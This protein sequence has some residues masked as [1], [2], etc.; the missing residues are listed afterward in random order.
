MVSLPKVS[1]ISNRNFVSLALPFPDQAGTG[2]AGMVALG[3]S[4]IGFLQKPL[5]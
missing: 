2:F 1:R 3:T 5:S 4:P